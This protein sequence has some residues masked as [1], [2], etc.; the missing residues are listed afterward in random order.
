MPQQSD[1]AISIHIGRLRRVLYVESHHR[2]IQAQDLAFIEVDR[3]G[4]RADITG[5]VYPAWQVLEFFTLN[6]LQRAN[7]Y[8]CRVGD[9]FERQRLLS[10]P[11]GQAQIRTILVLGGFPILFH[12]TP[13]GAGYAWY[14]RSTLARILN[15]VNP[16]L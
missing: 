13:R 11:T 3:A 1:D 9:L 2:I 7:A 8:L 14:Q 6:S 15:S 5:T 12:P 10:T 4:I 16:E